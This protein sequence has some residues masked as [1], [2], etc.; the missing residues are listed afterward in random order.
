MSIKKRYLFFLVIIFSIISTK[1]FA[2][3]TLQTDGVTAPTN[4]NIRN[5]NNRN[6]DTTFKKRDN[7]ED[8]ITI[9]YIKYNETK[10]RVLDTTIN[11][12]Y[13]RFPLSYTYNHLGN[14]GTAAYSLLFNPTLKVGFDAGFHQFDGYNFNLENTKLYQT[15]KPFTE[16]DYLLGSSAE[17][18]IN[19][20]HTQNRKDNINFSLEYRFINSPGI[21]KNQNA[22]VNNTRLV[23]QYNS[24]NKFYHL[25]TIYISNKNAS[26]ENGGTVDYKQLDSLSLNNPFELPVRLGLGG[27][28]RR[29]LFNTTVNTGNIYK[30][31]EFVIKHYYDFG[32]KDSLKIDSSKIKIFYPKFRLQHIFNY[33]KNEFAFQDIYADSANYANYFNYNIKTSSNTYDTIRFKDSWSIIKNE[34]S[35]ISF[36]DKKNTAQYIVVSASLENLVG[37]FQDT[38]IDKFHNIIIGGE[39]K[40]RSRNKVWDINANAQFYLNGLNTGDYLAYISIQKELGKKLGSLELGFQNTNKSPSFIYN[41]TS[42]FYIT[43][44]QSFLKENT[45]KLWA[46]YFNS[47]TGLLLKGEYF[48]LNNLLYFNNF[49]S[50][51]QESSVVNVLHLSLEKKFKLSK[52]INWYSELHFQQT[53]G[54]VPINIPTFFTR[55]RIAFEGNFYTNLFLST[56]LEIRYF[57]NYKPSGYSPFN[58]Q[59]FY[60]NSYTLTNRPAIDFYFNFRIRTFKIYFRAENL[61]T[62]IPPNGYKSYN[63]A[64]EQ[65]PMQT[66][67]L[68]LGIFWNFIN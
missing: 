5:N 37:R 16:L 64:V 44:R 57:T 47:K 14:L 22:S 55:Q 36:P 20:L 26:S 66:V 46:N 38:S 43:N 60:Q 50:V 3:R 42:S 8:S 18:M 11:D 65:Y 21:F 28:I 24:K 19:V 56:G 27:V 33:K 12:F 1:T 68:R 6:A 9:F 30:Q 2:Q 58:G 40:N 15:T 49:F 29:D 61:N 41:T 52:N 17:Q 32:Q 10:T 4:T 34:F 7:S 54:N 31:S 45:I 39:Y 51:Q 62:L 63:Y 13:S 67:W 35:L 25:N 53:T 48:L 59:F 23:F